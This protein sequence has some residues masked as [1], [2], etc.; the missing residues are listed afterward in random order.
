[1]AALAIWFSGM[2]LSLRA[3]LEIACL[4]APAVKKCIAIAFMFLTSWIGAIFYTFYAKEK[5][6]AW[7]S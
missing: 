4:K 2:T 7:L 6:E 5:M 3:I 1:M